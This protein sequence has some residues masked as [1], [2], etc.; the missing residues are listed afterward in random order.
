MPKCPA[1]LAAYLAA[2]TGLR[3]SLPV[4]A[5]VRL[6]LIILSRRARVSCLSRDRA[7]R[8]TAFSPLLAHSPPGE[9]AITAGFCT[10]EG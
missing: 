1:C 6:G 3:L 10:F 2:A 5:K 8:T 9:R 4:A 7:A